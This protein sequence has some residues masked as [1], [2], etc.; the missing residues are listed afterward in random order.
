[1]NFQSDLSTHKQP[2]SVPSSPPPL[3]PFFDHNTGKQISK[4]KE[5]YKKKQ[6]K[7]LTKDESNRNIKEEKKGLK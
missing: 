6:N 5:R 3:P 4:A 7:Q 2:I 1:L